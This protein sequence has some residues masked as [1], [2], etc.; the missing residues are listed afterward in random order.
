ML[1]SDG[2]SPN[3]TTSTAGGG[4][5]N[6]SMTRE[7]RLVLV[8]QRFRELEALKAWIVGDPTKTASAP[9]EP[10]EGSK[11]KGSKKGGEALDASQ[12][13]KVIGC[14]KLVGQARRT[15]MGSYEGE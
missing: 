3:T 1:P 12:L 8:D 10:E 9:K 15:L 5:S 2:H 7:R 13:K 4:K 6:Q 11:A 14:K